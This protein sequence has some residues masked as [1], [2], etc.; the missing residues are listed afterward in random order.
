ML[1]RLFNSSDLV[2]GLSLIF[3]FVLAVAIAITFHE[4]LHAYAAY[5]NGDPTAKFAGRMTLNPLAHIDPVG[6]L[7]LA[8]FGFGW[9]KPVPVNQYNFTNGRK[10]EVWVAIAGVL[11]NL[12]LGVCS[13]FLYIICLKFIPGFGAGVSGVLSVLELFLYYSMSINFVLAFFNLLPIYPLD[14]FKIVESTTSPNNGYVSFMKQYSLPVVLVLILLGGI[15]I[16]L[17]YTAYV[18]QD[19]VLLFWNWLFGLFGAWLW[20]KLSLLK[21]KVKMTIRLS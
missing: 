16:Y 5:K 13:A 17:S 7:M 1:F 15:E 6:I 20:Q 18:V 3:A 21:M 8:I 9:A 12:F 2:F 10:S 19:Y 4:F 11:G 14:G